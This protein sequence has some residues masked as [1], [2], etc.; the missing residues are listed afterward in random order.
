[1]QSEMKINKIQYV[2]LMTFLLFKACTC[3]ADI[4]NMLEEN[5][6][7]ILSEGDTLVYKSIDGD[8]IEIYVV[9]SVHDAYD[10]YEWRDHCD[11]KTYSQSRVFNFSGPDYEKV[12]KIIL[13]F[14]EYPYLIWN[15]NGLFGTCANYT[16]LNDSI[17]VG[18]TKYTLDLQIE[19]TE[20]CYFTGNM[21]YS[22]QIG[23]VSYMFEGPEFILIQI[24]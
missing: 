17:V 1:M 20:S 12:T 14:G 9:V 15:D 7:P 2:F 23:V 18:S 5:K 13:H 10:I 16:Q 24:K 8:S 3:P 6:I 11:T 21:L 22:N 4:Y 19:S